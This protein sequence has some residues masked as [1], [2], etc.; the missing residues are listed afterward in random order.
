MRMSM[1]LIVIWITALLTHAF[2]QT[3]VFPHLTDGT[4]GDGSRWSTEVDLVN[5]SL[6]QQTATVSFFNPDGTPKLV[7]FPRDT[8]LGTLSSVTFT[9]AP[10]Q[11]RV[12]QIDS[13]FQG[14]RP[15]QT[16][17][18][19]VEGSSGIKGLIIFRRIERPFVSKIIS[20]VAFLPHSPV[21]RIDFIPRIPT[22][23][24]GGPG[25]P[26]NVPMVAYA[27]V[28]PD[29]LITTAGDIHLF[30]ASNQQLIATSSFTLPPRGQLAEFIEQRFA[31]SLIGGNRVYVRVVVNT[32]RVSGIA[33]RVVGTSIASIAIN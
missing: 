9:F 16:G 4:I 22:L 10:E 14:D 13:G 3:L 7:V 24:S 5:T 12:V 33:L 8:G 19:L 26:E 31:G 15:L 20:E 27:L 32:G 28:N 11:L 25:A 1:S 17:W 6:S 2:G 18:V 29:P 23:A 21:S 30:D